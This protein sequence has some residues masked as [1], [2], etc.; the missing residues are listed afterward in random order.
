MP[1]GLL[2]TATTTTSVVGQPWIYVRWQATDGRL[3]YGTPFMVYI[4]SGD[5]A[6][7]APFAEQGLTF[8]AEQ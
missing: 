7:T 4:K 5:A 3:P 2:V 1:E 6:S 8:P